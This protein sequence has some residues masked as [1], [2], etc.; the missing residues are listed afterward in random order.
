MKPSSADS[1]IIYAWKTALDELE[2]QV[3][4]V[5]YV[6]YL[7]T[8]EPNGLISVEHVALRDIIIAK[9][10]RRASDRIND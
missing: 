9:V 6:N 2:P 4:V 5:D 8:I 10:Q 7:E 3:Q 1:V